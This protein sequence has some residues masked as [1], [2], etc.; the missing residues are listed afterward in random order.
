MIRK[1]RVRLTY[2][3]IIGIMIIITMLVILYYFITARMEK[4]EEQ[5]VPAILKMFANFSNKYI[6]ED[7]LANLNK[8]YNDIYGEKY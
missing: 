6:K 1:M 3:L 2:E 8:L 7:R 5:E 4:I